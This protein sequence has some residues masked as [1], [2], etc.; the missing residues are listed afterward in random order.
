[1]DK[2]R[3]TKP[4][5]LAIP[6]LCLTVLVSGSFACALSRIAVTVSPTPEKTATA[7]LFSVQ[8]F[9][10]TAYEIGEVAQA[11]DH[12]I[13]LNQVEFQDGRLMANFT[14]KNQGC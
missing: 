5:R 13:V 10:E 7:T 6:L 1:M 12:T 14:V 3:K 9:N 8:P 11:G 2:K 4:K